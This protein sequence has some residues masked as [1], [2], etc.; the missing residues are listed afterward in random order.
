MR[1]AISNE[2][3]TLNGKDYFMVEMPIKTE[4][5]SAALISYEVEFSFEFKTSRSTGLL[6]YAGDVND[7]LVL[8]LQ[9]GVILCKLNIRGEAFEKT[10]TVPGTFLNNEEWHSI[11]FTK[12]L[13]SIRI[14]IDD[15]IKEES[16]LDGEFISMSNKIIY[17]GGVPI[18]TNYRTIYKNFIGCI[19]N[20]FFKSDSHSYNLISLFLNNSNLVKE[21][22]KIERT[23]TNVMKPIT[24]SSPNSYIPILE[25]NSYP[26]LNSFTI[27][28]Q[29]N[30]KN[31]ILAYILGA[32]NTNNYLTQI[33]NLMSS[34]LLSLNRDFFSL[35]INEHFLIAYFNSGTSYIRHE[36]ANQQVSNGKSHQ[37]IVELNQ[38]YAIFK[39]DQNPETTI[40]ISSY[41]TN[42]LRLTAPLIIGGIYPNHSSLYQISS[43][44]PDQFYSVMHGN[45]FVGCILH[46]E[47]NEQK[48]NLTNFAIKEDV[49][50]VNFDICSPMPNQCDIGQCLNEGLCIEGWNRF[51]CDCSSTGFNGPICNQRKY[52]N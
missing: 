45:G 16:N 47:I 24:F 44:I 21:I 29:T 3:L 51:E 49:R 8:G 33:K 13:R 6:I 25:W 7:F 38:Q 35:E 34:K 1:A 28:F 50:G 42:I 15:L 31:G 37:V 10:L 17:V 52:M 23:C 48:I 32:E 11:K 2:E 5:N 46:L 26:I 12:N 14:V 4:Q 39:F 18:N 20:L 22:G 30:E 9:D 40:R 19:R 36:I 41:D 43:R 27:E